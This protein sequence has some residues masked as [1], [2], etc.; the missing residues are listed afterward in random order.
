MT[1]YFHT[2]AAYGLPGAVGHCPVDHRYTAML[3]I[4]DLVFFMTSKQYGVLVDL[5]DGFRGYCI[6]TL[7][8]ER[9]CYRRQFRL[10]DLSEIDYSK[11]A[12]RRFLEVHS[13]NAKARVA[14]SSALLTC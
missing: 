11:R 2:L 7:A 8:G 9:R 14:R 12:E 5:E 4:G 1:A 13:L 3:D 6:Q 10:A